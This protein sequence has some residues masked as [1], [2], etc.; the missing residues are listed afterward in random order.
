ATLIQSETVGNPPGSTTSLGPAAT[1]YV[2]H[3][4]VNCRP[5]YYNIQATDTT[6]CGNLSTAL[7]TPIMG[8]SVVT[9]QPAAPAVVTATRTSASSAVVSWSAVNT[10][11]STPAPRSILIDTYKIYRAQVTNCT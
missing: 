8:M 1:S 2:D 6:S 4:V 10:D 3:A 7:E 11:T 5:Y 9:I